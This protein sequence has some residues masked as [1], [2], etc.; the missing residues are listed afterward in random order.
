MGTPEPRHS[1]AVAILRR[2]G[3]RRLAQTASWLVALGLIALVFAATSHEASA[4]VQAN[5]GMGAIDAEGNFL[6][7]VH[8]S[9]EFYVNEGDPIRIEVGHVNAPENVNGIGRDV[10]F[11]IFIEDSNT[12]NGGWHATSGHY[13]RTLPAN[14]PHVHI[15]FPTRSNTAAG[16][17]DNVVEVHL[18]A[19]YS[20]T[21]HPRQNYV[22][23]A[24]Y[25]KF[26]IRDGDDDPNAT[27]TPTQQ[28]EPEQLP[29]G[30]PRLKYATLIETLETKIAEQ[31]NDV[32]K[33]F[34]KG[35]WKQVLKAFGHPQHK[36]YQPAAFTASR[37]RQWHTGGFGDIWREIADALDY[38]ESYVPGTTVEPPPDPVP[39]ITISGGS[40]ITE[41]QTASFTITA[42]PVPTSA[43]TVNVAATQ[44]GNWGATGA[45]TVSVS[46][47]TTTYVIR[48]ADDSTDEPDGSVTATVQ[49][50]SG[51]TLGTSSSATVTVSDNDL[52]PP[53]VLPVVTITGGGT[54]AEGG[55]TSF[56][57]SADTAPDS[58]ITVNIGLAQTGAY[59]A[60]GA[61]TV[62]LSGTS[63]SYTV[64]VP[65][66]NIDQANGSVTVTVN[67]GTGYT[68]GTNSTR[69]VAITDNDVPQI[70][71]SGGSGITEGGT[72]SFTITANPVPASAITVNVGVSESGAFGASGSATVSVSTATTTYTIS[73]TNDD[74]DE[75]NGSVTATVQSGSGYTLGS[76]S[77]ATVTVADNDVPP[78][79][80]LPVVTITGGST[81]AEGGSTSFTISADTAPDNP[82]TV[83]IGLSQ[84]GAFGATGS[85]TVSLSGTSAT[86]TVSVPNNN[87][88]Q[89]D[90]SVTVT[91]NSGTG[92][93]V[94]SSSSRTVAIIDNDVPQITI[95]GGSGITEGGTASFTISAS[96]VPAS[97]IT[98]NVGVS[99]SGSWGASGAA[100]VS[101]SS[102]TTTYTISTTN[103]DVDEPNGSVTATIQSGS[104]YTLGSASSATVAVSDNDVPPPVVLPVV[105]ISGGS[106]IAEGGST[107]FTISADTAPDSP[108]TVNIGL[109]QTGAYG[110][111][112][113]STVSLSGTSASYTVSVPNDDI[114]Q[115][116]GSVTVTVN[117]G[118]GYTVGTNSTRT[119][120]ITDNDVPQITISGGSGITEGG[121]ASF[122]ISASPVPASAITVN[123]GV[124]ESGA[125]GATGAATVS[126]SSATTTYTISTT[127][128]NVD[129]PNGSV[130]ATV[131]SGSDYTLG[132]PSTATVTVAD[133]DVSPPTTGNADTLIVSVSY[134]LDI[135]RPGE[136]MRFKITLSEAAE[137]DVTVKFTINSSGLWLDWDYQVKT[138]SP[139][140]IAK[141]AD[142]GWIEIEILEDALISGW[143]QIYVSLDSVSGAKGFG[144]DWSSGSVRE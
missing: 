77:S 142:H 114:D 16:D 124:S 58:P 128:D 33:N 113:A 11:N 101:V 67:S 85:S 110:A 28:P 144:Q 117:S 136:T 75:P 2:I 62:S 40:G 106:T 44:S 12:G 14:Q 79:V 9:K 42:D 31:T 143:P 56:T 70:T 118:T 103:D 80:V 109:S 120:S 99:E 137:Q 29:A 65:N 132:S 35:W 140:T 119:V 87:I 34:Y 36:N 46:S 18:L 60:T 45:A 96:P 108:I 91:V 24:N 88:D 8:H 59:G 95:S 83:N 121:A 94:G 107:S 53:V 71:I 131:Q 115:A 43:I 74:V 92:Y 3:R 134:N 48:T 123:V 73:T 138:S 17:G 100:T 54:I 81:I 57:I 116:N 139:L 93:T 82:I 27:P 26:V 5:L 89:A 51:Y 19:D 122:T 126:V 68:V 105:T 50:G 6:G 7:T 84:S 10:D 130:T 102:T 104:G 64:S 112:G 49:S 23:G 15:E 98:V 129:E 69:T 22:T 32:L 47:A 127:N 111:T 76:P 141:G 20:I 21:T 41:G 55:S 86:Y 90:G 66:N 63:A 133:N 125:F 61:S 1:V 4:S 97:P 38:V 39:E 30:H 13:I 135:T 78:P 72:A 52:P 25:L 37:A